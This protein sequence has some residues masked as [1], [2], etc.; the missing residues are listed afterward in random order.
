[1][2]QTISRNASVSVSATSTQAA[3]K[4][5]GGYVRTQIIITNMSA[6]AIVTIT[7]GIMPAV[8]GSGIRLP[9]NGSYL[10]S[11]DSFFRCWQDEIQVVADA[12]GTVAVV[13]QLEP[14]RV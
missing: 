4:V 9:P 1:M 6:A 11:S 7:K 2:T 8:A 3:N 14:A 10:E 5:M 13:E 12:A